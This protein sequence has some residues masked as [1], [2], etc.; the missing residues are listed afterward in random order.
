MS[1]L[2]HI[3]QIAH[4]SAIGTGQLISG[5]GSQDVLFDAPTVTDSQ[6]SRTSTELTINEDGILEVGY[7]YSSDGIVTFTLQLEIN[8]GG[9]YN[10]ISGTT[11]T[12]TVAVNQPAH[13]CNVT[14]SVSSGDKIKLTFNNIG[15]GGTNV[16]PGGT[17]LNA[18][19]YL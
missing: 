1:H 4:F 8:T 13:S 16:R 9:G 7:T 2:P 3:G 14:I 18:K 6:F 12:R 10:A 5:V 11:V 15:G 17:S 19:L